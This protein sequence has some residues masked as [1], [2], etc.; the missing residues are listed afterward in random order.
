MDN[1]TEVYKN[2]GAVYEN[3]APETAAPGNPAKA[4][5]VGWAGLGPVSVLFEYVF[6]IISDAANRKITWRL[7]RT[8]KHGVLRLPLGGASV[9]L[10]CERREN[11]EEEPVISVNST[12]PVTVEILWDGKRK[13]IET[14]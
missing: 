4:G 12:L 8:E 6:G 14:R 5:Y 3:Y 10:L 11:P 1:L 2:T 9:D 7:N 13:I